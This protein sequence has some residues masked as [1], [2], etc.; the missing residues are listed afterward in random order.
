MAPDELVLRQV[1]VTGQLVDVRVIGDAIAEVGAELRPSPG[2]TVVEGGGGALVPGLHDHHIHLLATAAAARSVRVGPDEVRDRAGFAATLHRADQAQASGV[3]LRAVGYHHSVAGDLDRDALDV[4]V[5]NRPIRVQDRSGARWTLNSAAI[6]SLGL[7]DH[8]RPELERNASGRLTGRLHR[9]DGWLRE[10]LPKEPE[11]DLAELGGR[12]ARLGVTGVTDATPYATVGALEPLRRAVADGS[13]PQRVWITGGHELAAVDAPDGLQRGPVKL[14]VD[15]AAYPA[16][17]ELAGWITAAHDQ[18]RSVAVHCVTRT[19]AVLA[20]GAW[21]AAGS[22]PGDRIEH[23]SVIPPAQ[24]EQIVRLQITVVTQPGF[25]GERGDEYL[26]DVDT[27]DLPY[28]YPCRSLLDAGA[29]VAGSTD[30][31]YTDPD[32]WRAMS[33]AVTRRSPSGAVVGPDEVISPRRALDLFLGDPTAPGGPPRRVEVG[34][35]ADLCLL[36]L[37]LDEALAAPD[38]IHVT[39]T[40]IGGALVV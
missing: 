16:L 38:Q 20:L 5:P 32:P 24:V 4:L 6:A 33:A 35:R 26:R 31:P 1:E 36:D 37:P 3:W 39:H 22:R 40:A 12:L 10:L 28:L 17:D 30:A 18:G 13:L 7:D 23:G 19:A 11:L 34:A 2:A 29:I 14:I 8:A 15:D 27:D 9:G 21:E 25:V